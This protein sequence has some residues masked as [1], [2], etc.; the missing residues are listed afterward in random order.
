MRFSFES[1]LQKG[2]F[3]LSVERM[4]DHKANPT[5]APTQ[6]SSPMS[7]SSGSEPGDWAEAYLKSTGNSRGAWAVRGR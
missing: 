7:Q 4:V 5:S 2:L 1:Y 3:F 6:E